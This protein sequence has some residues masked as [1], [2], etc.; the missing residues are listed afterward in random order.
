[1]FERAMIDFPFNFESIQTL[2]VCTDYYSQI[3]LAFLLL[4]PNPPPP[5]FSFRALRKENKNKCS[6]SLVITNVL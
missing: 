1:M 4:H 3:Q 2:L 5:S 6:K